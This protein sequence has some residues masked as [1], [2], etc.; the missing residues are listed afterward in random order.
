MGHGSGSGRSRPSAANIENGTSKVTPG[1]QDASGC[2]IL[3]T[4]G[5]QHG[6]VS[7]HDLDVVG[8]AVVDERNGAGVDRRAVQRRP[9]DASTPPFRIGDGDLVTRVQ[10]LPGDS[11]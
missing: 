2:R 8:A 6:S 4:A 5:W 3:D 9:Y 10:E 1:L 11:V 7:Q